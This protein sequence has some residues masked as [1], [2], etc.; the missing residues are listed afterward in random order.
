MTAESFLPPSAVLGTAP[1]A[2]NSDE[3]HFQYDSVTLQLDKVEFH[4]DF[5]AAQTSTSLSE[6][7]SW[8]MY[9]ASSITS[10]TSS[11]CFLSPRPVEL[12]VKLTVQKIVQKT[13]HVVFISASSNSR[14]TQQSQTS[15]SVPRR[16]FGTV[17]FDANSAQQDIQLNEDFS[18]GEEVFA[19]YGDHTANRFFRAQI[20]RIRQGKDS[21]SDVHFD[22][23]WLR[24]RHH[25]PKTAT[26]TNLSFAEQELETSAPD[27]LDY[28]M[29]HRELDDTVFMVNLP[30]TKLKRLD[31]SSN[32]HACGMVRFNVITG[33]PRSGRVSRGAASFPT[34]GGL[35]AGSTEFSRRHGAVQPGGAASTNS[36]R[37]SPSSSP[38]QQSSTTS[39]VGVQQFK[40]SFSTTTSQAAP[41]SIGA[42]RS[43]D[44]APGVQHHS[45]SSGTESGEHGAN[46]GSNFVTPSS[47]KDA[48]APPACFAHGDA[49]QQAGVLRYVYDG[50]HDDQAQFLPRLLPSPENG[51]SSSAGGLYPGKTS[52]SSSSLLKTNASLRGP[53][54]GWT[55]MNNKNKQSSSKTK[56]KPFTHL[57]RRANFDELKALALLRAGDAVPHED[58]REALAWTLRTLISVRENHDAQL[59]ELE[60]KQREL[61]GR[62]GR[63]E[64]E[65]GTSSALP[66]PYYDSASTPKQQK[67]GA[68]V[69]TSQN[70][71]PQ[72]FS[73][74]GGPPPPPHVTAS[75]QP[76]AASKYLFQSRAAAGSTATTTTSS[77]PATPTSN[78]ASAG[79]QHQQFQSQFQLRTSSSRFGGPTS[80]GVLAGAEASSVVNYQ[81]GGTAAH[82]PQ[83]VQLFYQTPASSAGSSKETNA[84]TSG[85]QGNNS[86]SSQFTTI[87]G[88]LLREQLYSAM[89]SS[90]SSSGTTSQ[91]HQQ[92]QQPLPLNLNA[93]STV[94]IA[95]AKPSSFSAPASKE[96]TTT[97][98]PNGNLIITTTTVREPQNPSVSWNQIFQSTAP[99]GAA[100]GVGPATAEH[101]V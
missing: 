17:S 20:S 62:L 59:A 101:L 85:H 24:P 73:T 29:N 99:S 81:A 100:G 72:F 32:S 43:Y 66:I 86:A 2:H 50:E 46:H 16:C 19:M 65:Y 40:S 35:V 12:N 84:S 48:A 77:K 25:T 49:K 31:A 96:T 75:Q 58:L 10:T 7:F 14:I 83:A 53:P 9:D 80:S 22:I 18:I 94:N 33:A 30:R 13:A 39:S 8:A 23:Q 42:D 5:L 28:V 79:H 78:L 54:P 68:L 88:D 60:N 37:V 95:G 38:N 61:F 55:T 36:M 63:Y 56:T 64:T 98:G 27:P 45:N 74:T 34:T 76:P 97:T 3:D 21:S 15:A 1:G 4:P 52:S 93:G 26:G 69:L 41:S 57:G 67:G 11:N 6:H 47:S 44:S 82:Q 51:E 89:S 87:S 91:R 92:A 90:T 70:N 71:N